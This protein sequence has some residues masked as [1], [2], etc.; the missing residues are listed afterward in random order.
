MADLDL[1][2]R[3]TVRVRIGVMFRFWVRFSGTICVDK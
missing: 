3:A 2:V 1:R